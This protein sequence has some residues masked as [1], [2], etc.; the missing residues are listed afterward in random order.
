M[1]IFFKVIQPP[2]GFTDDHQGANSGLVRTSSG[3]ERMSARCRLRIGTSRGSSALPNPGS[4][5]APRGGQRHYT[6][7]RLEILGYPYSAYWLYFVI[8]IGGLAVGFDPQ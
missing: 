2:T 5:D 6:F 4:P 1:Y 8:G 7:G 3:E